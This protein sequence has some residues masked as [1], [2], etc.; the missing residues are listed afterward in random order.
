MSRRAFVSLLVAVAILAPALLVLS[1]PASAVQETN[2]EIVA[3]LES[4][5]LYRSWLGIAP[6]KID[7]NLQ[8]ASEGHANY[9]RQNYGDPNLAGMGLHQQTP[10]KP[11]FTGA[12]MQDRANAAGYKGYVNE[13][14]GLSGSMIWSTDWFIGTINHRLT[15]LDPRYTHIGM[16]AVDEGDIKF[17]VI[18][19]GATEWTDESE[20][21]WAAWPPNNTTGVGLSFSGEAPNPF[22]GASFPTGYPITLTYHGPGELSLQSAT[23]TA[24][25][26]RVE[27]FSSVGSGWLSSK[28]AQI[29][30]STPMQNGTTYE[31]SATGTANGEPFIK[32]WSFTSTTGDDKLALDGRVAPSPGPSEPK[33]EPTVSPAPSQPVPVAPQAMNLP[34]GVKASHPAVQEMWWRSDGP[35]AQEQVKRSWLW[36]PDTWI[37]ISERYDEEPQRART[38]HYFDKARIEINT[39]ASQPPVT[40]GLLVRDMILGSIQV[41]DTAFVADSPAVVPLAGDAYEFNADAPTYASLNAIASIQEGRA[42]PQ[43]TG[44]AVVETLSTDGAIGSSQSVPGGVAYGSYDETLGHNVADVFDGYLSELA[45]DSVISVGL[46]LTEPYWV[47]TLV[48]QKPTWVLVQA[49]ERRLLTYTP[50]NEPEWQIEMGNVGRH[51]YEWRYDR[52]APDIYREPAG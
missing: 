26:Q 12:S 24:N 3:A 14:V 28:T 5:N 6:L 11:G 29:A 34:E 50:L 44:E 37:A 35:V 25:G 32:S 36:G 40:A 47:Q 30:T 21:E 38:V 7:P 51:Y 33:P 1:R 2:P 10:G 39:G 8:A 19:L 43:R 27:S 46:P 17:E 20:P 41:G 15:L 31:V 52:E 48:A 13:N 49:F 4:I 45:V 23:V 22:P 18:N 9:Y 16:A 42:I